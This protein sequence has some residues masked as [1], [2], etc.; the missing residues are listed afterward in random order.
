M[1]PSDDHIDDLGILLVY[2]ETMDGL[3][4]NDAHPVVARLYDEERD[5]FARHLRALHDAL[6]C[7][8]IGWSN[9]APEEARATSP[10]RCFIS[11]WAWGF[12]KNCGRNA[13][14]AEPQCVLDAAGFSHSLL[15][16]LDEEDL[17]SLSSSLAAAV[18][19]AYKGGE[20]IQ[21]AAEKKM[22]H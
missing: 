11:D 3:Q 19:A 14:E 16:C 7:L 9:D 18:I 17:E 20:N 13:L 4:P 8:L 5:E 22:V 1:H 21:H 6:P 12:F 2:S 10:Q 15:S